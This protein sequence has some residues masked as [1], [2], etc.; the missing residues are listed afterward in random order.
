MARLEWTLVLRLPVFFVA[1]ANLVVGIIGGIVKLPQSPLSLADW[2]LQAVSQHGPMM[3]VGFF[4]TLISL[5]RVVAVNRIWAYPIAWVMAVSGAL[6]VSG[7]SYR[8][9][10]AFAIAGGALLSLL[11]LAVATRLKSGDLAVMSLA[12][13]CLTVGCAVWG[14]TSVPGAV[15]WWIAFLVLTIA[16]ERRE[17]SKWNRR[18]H[19]I[20]WL[21]WPT[22]LAVVIGCILS[23]FRFSTGARLAGLGWLA[24]GLLLLRG[25]IVLPFLWIP[26]WQRFLAAC[27]A[28]GYVWLL[29]GGALWLVSPPAAGFGPAY[30][31]AL[32]AVFLGF[33]FSAVFGHATIVGAS[34]LNVQLEY[35]PL[36]YIPLFL[37]HTSV[38]LRI[39][40][41]YAGGADIVTMA[42]LLNAA[43]IVLF[44]VILVGNRLWMSYCAPKSG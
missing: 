41:D 34:V 37:L 16:A 42:G 1:V 29:S 36:L 39:W 10:A 35:T 13:V 22:V 17:L 4:A 11:I 19:Q 30:D 7:S 43:A 15:P 3:V 14:L 27:L 12:A 5:E 9:A 32:H 38:A 2:N 28:A 40:G 18:W 31:R 21:F 24:V 25:D 23:L 20:R 33:V 26:G 6:L 44:P 8:L